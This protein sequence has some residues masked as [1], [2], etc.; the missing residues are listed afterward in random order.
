MLRTRKRRANTGACIGRLGLPIALIAASLPAKASVIQ[1]ATPQ[2]INQCIISGGENYGR[3]MQTCTRTSEEM[4]LLRP[5]GNDQDEPVRDSDG[6]YIQEYLY[7][8]P[9]PITVEF[10]LCGRDIL[11]VSGAS[12]N[13]RAVASR[14]LESDRPTCIKM[15]FME[16]RG[17]F[18]LAV[19]TR[20]AEAEV[21]VEAAVVASMPPPTIFMPPPPPPLPPVIFTPH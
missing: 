16:I 3:Q 2:I 10:N 8:I 19:R 4:I 7:R 9:E 6:T 21:N 17:N 1:P 12:L 11:N 13:G 15:R 18:L 20:G 5:R 14:R